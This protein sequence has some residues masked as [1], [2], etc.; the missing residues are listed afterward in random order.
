MSTL[1]ISDLHLDAARPQATAAF[2]HF[3]AGR[4]RTAEALYVLGDLFESWV[5]DDDDSELA[6]TVASALHGVAASGVAVYFTRGN[7]DFLLGPAYARRCDMQLLADPAVSLIAGLP[8]LLLH[9]DLLCTDDLDYQRFRAQ[10]RSP[11]WQTRFLAQTL[12]ERRA[13]AASARAASRAHQQAI[14]DA[15]GDANPDSVVDMLQRYGLT[16]MIH[17]HTHRP[18][19]HRH[20]ERERC[21]LGDWYTQGS[22]LE[23][24]DDAGMHLHTLPFTAAPL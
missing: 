18:A 3:C 11:E 17:G 21:V 9:G 23:I 15:I 16:R 5:G 7:R 4:A 24:A 8:T 6:T 22:V 14:A 19:M 13:F 1:F 10:V 2:L 12:A 20:G